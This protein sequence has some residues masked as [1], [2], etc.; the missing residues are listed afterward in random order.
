MVLN[1]FLDCAMAL[2]LNN[3]ILAGEYPISGSVTVLNGPAFT[4]D[5]TLIVAIPSSPIASDLQQTLFSQDNKGYLRT[6]VSGV[7]S[8][9]VLINAPD[10][11]E[12]FN[13]VKVTSAT[14]IQ[15]GQSV[16]LLITW[17]TAF[18]TSDYVIESSAWSQ[19]NTPLVTNT[20]V[21]QTT[22]NATIQI[23]NTG[24]LPTQGS[25]VLDVLAKSIP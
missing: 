24:S 5:A 11:I 18:P 25:F 7:W 23:T 15:P 8:S 1:N 17:P 3:I 12:G 16:T 10:I 19:A 14:I 2:D 6:Y 20:L 21:G 9:W 13:P 4:G 22:T